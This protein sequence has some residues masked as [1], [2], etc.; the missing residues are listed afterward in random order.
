M[1][2]SVSAAAPGGGVTLSGYENMPLQNAESTTFA[3]GLGTWHV[4]PFVVPQALA[5]GRMNALMVSYSNTSAGVLR[6]STGSIFGSNTTGTA[7]ATYQDVWSA[8]LYSRGAGANS[9]RLDRFW[10]NTWGLSLTRQVSVILTNATQV[11]VT[12]SAS[13]SYVASVGSDG[14][15]TL[16]G[17][18]SGGSTSSGASSMNTTAIS[19]VMSSMANMLTGQYLAPMGF[20][21]S[22]PAGHYW[23]AIARST[24]STSAGSNLGDQ[25]PFVNRHFVYGLSSMPH[26]LFGLTVSN[27]SSQYWPGAGIY[28]A[29]SSEPPATMEFTQIRSVNSHLSQYFNV[30]N[31]TV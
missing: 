2:V 10:S 27:T 29:A 11:R 6:A 9:T 25:L 3:Q 31:I 14:A 4:Q 19:S 1:T 23:L 17:A 13:L 16:A 7:S 20:N 5:S 8:A 22:I 24:F 21:T 15:Y 26:R 30:V 12:N 18:T 28:S